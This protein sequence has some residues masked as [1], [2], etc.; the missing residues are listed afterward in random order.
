M[1]QGQFRPRAARSATADPLHSIRQSVIAS[2]W[3]LRDDDKYDPDR[4]EANRNGCQRQQYVDCDVCALR[5]GRVGQF[6]DILSDIEDDDDDARDVGES[7]M[8]SN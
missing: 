7:E 1:Q 5:S 8:S 2:P 3:C 6:V 4:G